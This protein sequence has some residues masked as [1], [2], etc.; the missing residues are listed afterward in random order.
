MFSSSGLKFAMLWLFHFPSGSSSSAAAASAILSWYSRQIKT[1]KSSSSS[2]PFCVD[3]AAFDLL[4]Y[5]GSSLHFIFYLLLLRCC[6]LIRR[7]TSRRRRPAGTTQPN[8]FPFFVLFGIVLYGTIPC[9]IRHTYFLWCSRK[10]YYLCLWYCTVHIPF[11]IQ[12]GVLQHDSSQHQS[13]I[14]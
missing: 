12:M 1:P 8:N 2:C 7:L 11:V 14:K 5:F 13:G 3:A 10:Q 4:F 6:L 9:Y